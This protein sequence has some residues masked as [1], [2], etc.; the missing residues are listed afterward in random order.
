MQR[1][2]Q[3]RWFA[4]VANLAAFSLCAMA[5]FARNANALFY[6]FDGSYALLQARHQ[7]ASAQ[8]LFSF[9]S[10]FLQSIGNIQSGQNVRLL[11]FFWPIGWFS[12]LRAEKV[13]AY[14]IIAAMVFLATYVVARLLEQPRIIALTAAWII[15]VVTTPFVPRPFFYEILAVWPTF[16]LAVAAPAVVFWLVSKAGRSRHLVVDAAVVLGLVALAFYLLAAAPIFLP[17]YAFGAALYAALSLLLA[18]SRPELWRKLAVLAAAL[19]IM[20]ALRWPWYI[21]GLFLDTAASVF[22]Q[23]YSAV[24]HS[25][26]FASVFFQYWQFGAAGTLL[27]L[28]AAAGAA[29]SLRSSA[30]PQRI[31]A[32]MVLAFIAALLASAVVLSTTPRWIAPPPVYFEM[33][34]WPLYGTFAAVTLNRVGAFFDARLQAAKLWRG[35]SVR[36]S[37][38][39]LIAAGIFAALVVIKR[40][41]TVSGYPFPPRITPVVAELQA[42]IALSAHATFNG[43]VATLVPVRSDAGDAWS[44]QFFASTKWAETSGNDEMSLGLWYFRIPTLFEYNQFIAP[45]FQYLIKRVLQSPSITY[46]RNITVITVPDLRALQLTG[47]RYVL[48]PN[49]DPSLG[50]LRVT[51]DRNGQRW[52]LVELPQPNLG[53]YS[54]TMIETRRDLASAFDF[55]LDRNVDLTKA[56][57]VQ[58]PIGGTLVPLASS[59]LAMSGPDLRVTAESAGRSLL[60]VPMEFSHCIQMRDANAGTDAAAKLARVD[61]LLTGIV[62]ERHLDITLAFRFGPLRNPTCRWQDYREL[63]AML[64]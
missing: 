21:F 42:K 49:P 43:R 64:H 14:V 17:L 2:R 48:M 29:L 4:V 51:E 32:W 10:E 8:P 55:V 23:D 39:L 59:A 54:P 62:F 58:Q 3:Q 53:S 56:A 11:F 41:P 12:D 16:V 20:I 6:H 60:V 30:A 57:V 1:L 22:P 25:V 28:A 37:L 40:A 36:P 34:A 18:R 61:G 27:V 46:E 44:Q 15:G 35:L 33:A 26:L 63:R 5:A 38:A 7:L 50:A 52:G 24:Y 19:L 9:T 45:L 47:V 31:A 13:A